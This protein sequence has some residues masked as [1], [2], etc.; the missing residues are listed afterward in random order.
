MKNTVSVVIALAV[1][2]GMAWVMWTFKWWIICISL[3]IVL[4]N[5]AIERIT[6]KPTKLHTW[7]KKQ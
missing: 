6:G 5:M 1:L 2:G 4:I 3:V 7:A